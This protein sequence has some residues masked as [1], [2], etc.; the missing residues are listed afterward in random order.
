MVTEKGSHGHS[1]NLPATLCEVFKAKQV[2]G[3]THIWLRALH[4]TVEIFWNDGDNKVKCFLTGLTMHTHTTA[5]SLFRFY[6]DVHV[7]PVFFT[8]SI[9]HNC[10]LSISVL[11]RCACLTCF[12]YNFHPTQLHSLFFHSVSMSCP[13]HHAES[14][15]LVSQFATISIS[16]WNASW[17]CYKG[18]TC[19]R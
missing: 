4:T 1:E 5:L 10:T 11:S 18:Y 3:S 15:K 8:T 9:P 16:L 19:V 2:K 12:L 17:S 6:L 13:I 7:S 14:T